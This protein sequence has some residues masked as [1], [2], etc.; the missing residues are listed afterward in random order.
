M[1]FFSEFFPLSDIFSQN[2]LS[3]KNRNSQERQ[4]FLDNFVTERQNFVENF[5]A[6]TKFSSDRTSCDNVAPKKVSHHSAQVQSGLV[7]LSRHGH[8]VSQQGITPSEN[9]AP[10][11][12]W[13]GVVEHNSERDWILSRKKL[14]KAVVWKKKNAFP[15]LLLW[16]W[17]FESQG[18]FW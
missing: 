1:L 13:G 15:Q 14:F 12:G 17:M 8:V 2:I 11:W 5:L 4:N 3:L 16:S 9:F 18:S 6:A 10:K 7:K